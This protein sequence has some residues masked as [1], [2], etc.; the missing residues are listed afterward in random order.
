[1]NFSE[2]YALN[3][4]LLF[5]RK[6]ENKKEFKVRVRIVGHDKGILRTAVISECQLH[7]QLIMK[8]DS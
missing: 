1:M 3:L 8:F 6:H 4:V 7:L 2:K 5:S